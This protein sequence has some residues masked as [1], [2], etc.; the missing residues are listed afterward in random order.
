MGFS[1][2]CVFTG[3]P[4]EVGGCLG[5]GSATAQGGAEDFDFGAPVLQLFKLCFARARSQGQ[6]NEEEHEIRVFYLEHR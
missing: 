1:E 4:I 5:R 2:H 3:K 6:M